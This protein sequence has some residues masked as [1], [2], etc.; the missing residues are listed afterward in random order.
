MVGNFKIQSLN[1]SMWLGIPEKEYNNR[2]SR[3]KTNLSILPPPL[4]HAQRRRKKAYCIGLYRTVSVFLRLLRKLP[5]ADWKG[6][7]F[8]KPSNLLYP[9][10]P[11][12]VYI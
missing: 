1:S 9:T 11:Q 12:N 3:R 7:Y 2:F 4:T 10:I 6:W 5:H 8:L